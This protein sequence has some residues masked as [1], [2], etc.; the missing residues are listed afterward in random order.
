M[1]C[2]FFFRADSPA[3][4]RSRPSLNTSPQLHP[5]TP[6]ALGRPA[7]KR[8][9]RTFSVERAQAIGKRAFNVITNFSE[10]RLSGLASLARATARNDRRLRLVRRRRQT[11]RGSSGRACRH[12]SSTRQRP[13]SLRCL[14][15]TELPPLFAIVAF[16]RWG[17]GR[18][19]AGTAAR[20]VHRVQSERA[21]CVLTCDE[22]KR[23]LGVDLRSGKCRARYSAQDALKSDIRSIL[24][25]RP[26]L[27][28]PSS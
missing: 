6:A 12:A 8:I 19:H 1:S 5:H 20:S 26:L 17:P 3:E 18:H 14:L 23:Y 28:L 10:G 24:V 15:N 11:G 4:T 21:Q 7:R 2:L 22:Y 27:P 9:R 25:A 16:A 13:M